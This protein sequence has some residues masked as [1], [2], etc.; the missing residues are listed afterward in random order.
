[1]EIYLLITIIAAI[2]IITTG[3]IGTLAV[4]QR[5]KLQGGPDLPVLMESPTIS[6]DRRMFFWL[7]IIGLCFV[8]FAGFTSWFVLYNVTATNHSWCTILNTINASAAH[9]AA[10]APPVSSYGKAL[11]QDFKSLAVTFRC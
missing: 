11:I 9:P 4:R 7:I 8:L 6:I 5:E 1:M 2:A 10:H 3:V